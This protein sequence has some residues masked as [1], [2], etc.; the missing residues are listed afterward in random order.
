MEEGQGEKAEEMEEGLAPQE[1]KFK[2][3]VEGAGW[4]FKQ[5]SL[6]NDGEESWEVLLSPV[7]IGSVKVLEE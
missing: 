7:E 6:P 5:L 2:R 4:A 1:P 3:N